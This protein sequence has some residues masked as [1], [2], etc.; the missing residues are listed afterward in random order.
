MKTGMGTSQGGG[1]K[2]L[3]PTTRSEAERQPPREGGETSKKL[4]MN[5]DLG[6]QSKPNTRNHPP[7]P[8]PE[9]PVGAGGATGSTSRPVSRPQLSRK[10]THSG[11]GSLG[12][13]GGGGV[14]HWNFC[15]SYVPSKQWSTIWKPSDGVGLTMRKN[16]TPRQSAFV[17]L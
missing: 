1:G 17:G 6:A 11:N 4:P 10:G 7:R 2:G 9:A 16:T 14:W 8:S 12:H 5:A 3:V 15:G 13:F